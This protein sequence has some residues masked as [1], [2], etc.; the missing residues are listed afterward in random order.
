MAKHRK[1]DNAAEG[2]GSSDEEMEPTG[3]EVC[4][5]L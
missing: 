5:V 2:E 1:V 4:H 3:L